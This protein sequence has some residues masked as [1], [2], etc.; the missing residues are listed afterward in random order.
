M[1]IRIFLF[2]ILGS[3]R[4][5]ITRCVLRAPLFDSGGL[6]GHSF[7]FFKSLIFLFCQIFKHG[8]CLRLQFNWWGHF[9]IRIIFLTVFWLTHSFPFRGIF[10]HRGLLSNVKLL[11]FPIL[12][13]WLSL[14]LLI[15][16]LILRIKMTFTL[17]FSCRT[18]LII[19][20]CLLSIIWTL[21]R[22]L[23]S[24]LSDGFVN[25]WWMIE[26]RFSLIILIIWWYRSIRAVFPDSLVVYFDIL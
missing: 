4:G 8:S 23:W 5:L 2:F 13:S 12:L 1:I 10:S 6:H 16:K 22:S 9:C 15:F 3:R 18:S 24:F 21:P 7:I 19:N 25:G 17:F 11:K 26:L 14:I 20:F